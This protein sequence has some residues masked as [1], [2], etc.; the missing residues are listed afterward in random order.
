MWEREVRG[1]WEREVRGS[2]GERG[3]GECRRER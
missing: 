1:V 3:E 2:V